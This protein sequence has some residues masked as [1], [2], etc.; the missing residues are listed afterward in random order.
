M[1]HDSRADALLSGRVAVVT[2]GGGG[3]G[4]ATARVFA[5]QGAHVVIVDVDAGLAEGTVDEFAAAF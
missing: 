2:G 1:N 3:I 5:G 4:A